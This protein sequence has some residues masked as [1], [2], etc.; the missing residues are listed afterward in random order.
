MMP[1]LKIRPVEEAFRSGKLEMSTVVEDNAQNI[2]ASDPEN[3][4]ISILM[5]FIGILFL[6]NLGKFIRLF[7]SLSGSLVNRHIGFNLEHDERNVRSRTLLALLVMLPLSLTADKTGLIS[8]GF[9]SGLGHI[10]RS[11]LLAVALI[12][13]Y[14]S[15]NL[16]FYLPRPRRCSLDVW[17]SVTKDWINVFLLF[18]I[19]GLVSSLVLELCGASAG[20]VKVI[21]IV[22]FA[23]FFFIHFLK[24]QQ[25][26]REYCSALGSILYLCGLE[27]I[28]TGI[29]VLLGLI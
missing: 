19:T 2:A 10:W 22:L 23:L 16:L 11:I 12:I 27:I 28:P 20:L 25:I 26:L 8:P 15:R 4:V 13:Y 1:L 6:V 14:F 24:N 7:P 29:L 3:V 21:L 18:S 5:V 9:L 17:K